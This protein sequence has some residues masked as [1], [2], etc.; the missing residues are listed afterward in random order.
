MGAILPALTMLATMN[1]PPFYRVRD[2]VLVC[3]RW[4]HLCL[5]NPPQQE[6]LTLTLDASTRSSYL[7]WLARTGK[8]V[9]KTEVIL[10]DLQ[11]PR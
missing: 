9:Q 5:E 2:V 4:S 1:H 10:P 8:A 7:R 11:V 3:K 6:A